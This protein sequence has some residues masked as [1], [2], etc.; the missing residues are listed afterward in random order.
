LCT[1]RRSR[2]AKHRPILIAPGYPLNALDMAYFCP[3]LIRANGRVPARSEG[4]V[5][6]DGKSWQ[7]WSRHR[8]SENPWVP[9]EDNLEG[10]Y[11][12]YIRA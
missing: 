11:F 5:E 2:P 4:R 12:F 7:G 8:T 10:H 1:E 6:I 9:D 3:P